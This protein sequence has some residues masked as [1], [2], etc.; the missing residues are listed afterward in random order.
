MFDFV[1]LEASFT[2]GVAPGSDDNVVPVV[3][4]KGPSG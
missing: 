2:A 4:E 1:V 3:G